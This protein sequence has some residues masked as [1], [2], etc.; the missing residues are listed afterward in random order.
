MED[1]VNLEEAL[2]KLNQTKPWIPAGDM[3]SAKIK[4][5]DTIKWIKRKVKEQKALKDWEPLAFTSTEVE[6]KVADMQK[7]VEKLKK[8]T[9]PKAK[10]RNK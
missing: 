4:L 1:L 8:T 6:K 2:T 5:N 10:V 3:L 9:K 7:Q